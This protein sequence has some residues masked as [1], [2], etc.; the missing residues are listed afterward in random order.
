MIAGIIHLGN[1]EFREAGNDGTEV[2]N[3]SSLETT[4]RILQ[5]TPQQL[6]DSLCKQIVAAKGDIVSKEHNVDAALYTRDA[7]AKVGKRC[8][9]RK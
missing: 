9:T 5:V 7:L 3:R 4:A 1:L 8:I 6:S 2:V